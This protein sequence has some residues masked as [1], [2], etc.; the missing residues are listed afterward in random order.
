MEDENG[1][2]MVTS[3]E[4]ICKLRDEHVKR[5]SNTTNLFIHLKCHHFV[6]HEEIVLAAR[7]EQT[8]LPE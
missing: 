2:A 3:H 6:K 1:D 5:S 4:A 8:E 7:R